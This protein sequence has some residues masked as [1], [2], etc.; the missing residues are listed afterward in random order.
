M[1]NKTGK[2]GWKKGTSGNSKGR[3]PI[4]L[5]EVRRAIDANKNAIKV[6]ILEEM[7]VVHQGEE[8]VR[9][10]VK[11]ILERA[12]NDGDAVKL[13]TLLEMALGKLVEDPEPF[14]ISADEKALVLTYRKRCERL[15]ESSD[16]G[17][18]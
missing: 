2:G 17:T 11:Q 6:M 1:A 9:T 16:G 13:K 4:I 3:S 12:I 5:P 7:N 10:A 8:K 15:S 18:S 14:P